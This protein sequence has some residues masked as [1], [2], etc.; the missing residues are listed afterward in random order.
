MQVRYFIFLK[1]K[2]N[3]VKS[4]FLRFRREISMVYYYFS[5]Q[6]CI[7]PFFIISKNNTYMSIPFFPLST[8]VKTF[9]R[10][11]LLLAPLCTA[12]SILHACENVR[13]VSVC[14]RRFAHLCRRLVAHTHTHTHFHI[15]CIDFSLLLFCRRLVFVLLLFAVSFLI[16]TQTAPMPAG[17]FNRVAAA[18]TATASAS[19]ARAVC[20]CCCCGCCLCP[21]RG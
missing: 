14:P 16:I 4:F 13:C 5:Y 12:R 11:F 21:R 15:V 17:I 20:C 9:W 10:V 19:S 7:K 18:A 1:T 2:L 6:S 8:M 3:I